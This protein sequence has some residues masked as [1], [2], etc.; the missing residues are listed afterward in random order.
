LEL[1]LRAVRLPRLAAWF[2]LRPE[3]GATAARPLTGL[4]DFDPP[5]NA[6]EVRWARSVVRVMRHWPWGRG[7]CLRQ[8]LVLGH[9]LRRRRP[10]LRIGVKLAASGAAAHAWLEVSG[11]AIDDQGFL[12]LARDV[13]GAP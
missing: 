7:T 12:P 6:R 9:L 11:V 13:N 2:G 10:L 8:S 4:S 5:L 1:L 3:W